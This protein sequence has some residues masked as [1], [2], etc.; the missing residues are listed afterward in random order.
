MIYELTFYTITNQKKGFP[1]DFWIKE[2]INFM[3]PNELFNDYS[4]QIQHLDPIHLV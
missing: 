2:S 4:L 3:H 1:N